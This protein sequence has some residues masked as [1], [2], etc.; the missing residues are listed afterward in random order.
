[1]R[2]P[3]VFAGLA[4]L[5][6]IPGAASPMLPQTSERWYEIIGPQGQLIGFQ[7][8]ISR[9]VGAGGAHERVRRR[10]LAYRIEGHLVTRQQL[11]LTRRY[12]AAGQLTEF[13]AVQ[14]LGKLRVVVD[15]EITDGTLNLVRTVGEQRTTRSQAMPVGLALGDAL[16]GEQSEG[17]ALELAPSGLR[18]ERRALR[19]NAAPQDAQLRTALI[20]G[21]LV[22]AEIVRADGVIE[23]PRLGYSLLLRPSQHPLSARDIAGVRRIP[24]EMWRSPFYVSAAALRGH[25]RY[26]F[27]WRFGFDG[28]IPATG[29]QAAKLLGPAQ[30][31]DICPSCG[32]GLAQDQASL[33]RWRRPAPW[34]ESAA[35]QFSSAV[36]G[37]GKGGSERARMLSLGKIARAR[38]ART[39][40]EGHYSALTAWRRGA[41]DC[42]EDAVVY[43]ALARAAGIPARVASGLVY[44]RSSYHGAANAFLPHTWVLAW[45]DGRWD[46]FD[47]SLDGFDASHIALSIGDGEPGAIQEA[48]QLA[49]LLDW[50][51]MTEVRSRN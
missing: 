20:G 3:R 49:A 26:Q 39:D 1:M 31:L 41:G 33:E 36:R 13:Q 5:V 27:G 35:P 14:V 22:G 11:E 6:L 16:A 38:L 29:E 25:I 40:F 7:H 50:Q 2:L 37:L 10:D 8:E 51:A 12:D 47:I 44:S 28:A 32:P 4:A 30:Q 24:H 23:L 19:V 46:S 45:V 17:V 21:R 15:G 9:P 34:I 43:A 42:T 18:L 48:G